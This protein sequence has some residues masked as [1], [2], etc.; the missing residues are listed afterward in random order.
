[1]SA[2]VR[3]R[4][5]A[6]VAAAV[7]ALLLVLVSTTPAQAFT[8]YTPSGGS[9]VELRSSN[10]TLTNASTGM[11]LVCGNGPSYRFDLGGTVVNPGASRPYGAAAASLTTL[12]TAPA[13]VC[14]HPYC[15]APVT[16]TGTWSLSMTGDPTAGSWPA[17]LSGVRMRLDC[18]GYFG[19]P[20]RFTLVGSIDGRFAPATQRFTPS[21]GYDLVVEDPWVCPDIDVLQGDP[22][23][24][25][26][27]WTN[28]PPSG[29]SP[30]LIANP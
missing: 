20:C 4:F 19:M 26:G 13:V 9:Q 11:N 30:L 12:T 17:R 24:V 1:M 27:Y 8:T 18:A 23:Q 2:L 5:L 28:V 10:I 15:H 14:H 25:G 29:S 16:M 7:L 22:F 21:A 3:R 6:P